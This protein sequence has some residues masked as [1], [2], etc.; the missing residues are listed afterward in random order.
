MNSIGRIIGISILVPLVTAFG[1]TIHVPGDY[2]SIQAAIDVSIDGDTVLV[3]NGDYSENI[4]FQGKAIVLTSENGPDVTTI[5]IQ[6]SG[7]PVILFSNS[8]ARNSVLSGFT[9]Q[10]DSSYW[11]ISCNSAS[12]TIYGNVV[13]GHEVGIMVD[14]GGPLIRNNDIAYCYHSDIAPE[15]SGGISI[16]GSNAAIDSNVIHHNRAHVAAA[17]SIN[18]SVNITFER[19]VIYSN[20]ASDYI[21]GVVLN[22]SILVH[23]QNNT[24]VDNSNEFLD[25]GSLYYHHCEDVDIINNIVASNDEWGV[26][27]NGDNTNI[28]IDYNDIYGNLAGDYHGIDPGL[29]DISDDPLF[30]GGEPFSFELTADSPCIDAGDPNSPPDPDGTIADMGAFYFSHS[31]TSFGL[32][33]A[34][35]YGENSQLAE[36]PVSAY[37]LQDQ[38]IAGVEFHIAYDDVCLE[39]TDVSSDYLTDPLINVADGVIHLLWEDYQNPV[40]VSDS[41]SIMEIEFAVLGEL[42]DS[43]LVQWTGNNEL[44]DPQGET[45]PDLDWLDGSV[46]VVEF[47]DISGNVV[48]YDLGTPVPD[49]TIDLAGDFQET[50]VSDEN[51]AYIFENIF[52]GDFTICPSRADDDVGVTVADI[53][54]IRRH[55][56][57]LE[58]FDSPY[59]LIAAD[60]NESGGVTVADVIKMR[61]Y[62]ADLE[63]LPSGNWSFVDSSFAI[64]DGNWA[65]APACIEATLWD[66]DLSDSSFV[67]IRMGDV[68]HSWA[69]GRRGIA[70]PKVTDTAVLDLA[71]C[72]GLPGDTVHMPVNV[73]GFDGV[74]G[75]E[76]HFEY[77]DDGMQYIEIGS[78]VVDDPTTNGYEGAI[79]FVWEDIFDVVELGDGEEIV[80]IAFEIL[81]GAEDSMLVSFTAAYVVDEEG[82]DFTVESSD[83]YVL[84]QQTPHDGD[85]SKIPRSYSLGQ[86]YPNPFNAQTIIDFGLPRSSDVVI[87]IYDLLGRQVAALTHG[88]FD[89][90][91]HQVTWDAAD[92]PSGIYFYTIKADD[93]TD[94]RKMLVLK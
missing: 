41:A 53:V 17:V 47:H 16:H 40:T 46:F 64:D 61:R 8:E 56:V 65:D 55:I 45:I 14:G 4:N 70:P 48:Y 6:T 25:Q 1:S 81:E 76:M 74:A 87:E 84:Q 23:F 5:E 58:I 92:Q 67:G 31:M 38:A 18:Y 37:G 77:P 27:D 10:G 71:D 3:A 32:D 90:G 22:N 9:I 36:I 88:F 51:G 73:A 21:G 54:L 50:T 75:L 68:D 52:P 59:K 7:S 19:N 49:V 24:I 79:H 33:I 28:I 42:G 20:T 80:F 57:W 62:L 93:Y 30:V 29:N 85:N 89:A 72:F 86:N 34:D 91:Y 66:T 69:Q 94:S 26:W 35:V 39:F 82:L 78:D 11:G 43:C 44:V 15:V 60:V 63:E 83:G 13:K 12:P 2:P